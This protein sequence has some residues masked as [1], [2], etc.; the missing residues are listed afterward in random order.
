MTTIVLAED[1]KLVREG[2][3]SL[4]KR[5]PTLKV[6][7]EANDGLDAIKLVE[8]LK[9]GLLLLDLMMPRIHG[10]EVLRQVRKLQTTRVIVVSMHTGEPH[11]SEAFRNGASGYVLKD[12][13][14]A[15]LLQA[16][17][18]A[19]AGRLYISPA[20]DHLV[21]S[22]VNDRS[23]S[24]SDIFGAL[25]ARERTVLQLTAEGQTSAQVGRQLFI[26][27]RTVES[28]R[29]NLMKKLSLRTQT[30]IVR[31]AI[32]KKIINP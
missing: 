14:V 11:V 2:L 5:D 30:D 24:D 31:F 7:G 23:S 13:S 3:C 27:R 10:L 9:P 6:V 29:A 20:L 21:L 22:R 1:H 25:S 8:T 16:I 18:A 26:S 19:L 4:L 28:H 15:E 17:K 12:S 32:R